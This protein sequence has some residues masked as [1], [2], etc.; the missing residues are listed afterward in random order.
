[1]AE[2]MTLKMVRDEMRMIQGNVR[3][4]CTKEN[5]GEWADAIDAHL[6]QPAQAVD[7]RAVT[8]A[9]RL[10]RALWREYY[11]DDAPQWEPLTGE[12]MGLLSQIENMTTGLTRAIGNAQADVD[13]LVIRL[14]EV[15]TRLEAANALL[16]TIRG[17]I[18]ETR[19]AYAG[20]VV[21]EI[22]AHLSEPRT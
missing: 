22:D 3:V 7:V 9:E 15:T 5:V 20:D 17:C 1:M 19:G 21:R 14:G 13:P 2:K 4:T 11:A 8:Y 10:A 18:N 6:A 12:L 16:R